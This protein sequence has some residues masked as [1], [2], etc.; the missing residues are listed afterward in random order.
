MHPLKKVGDT[1]ERISWEQAIDE[2]AEKLTA[3]VNEHG[4]RS[5]A[6]MMGGGN[7]GCP[8]P[9][10][11]AV[12]VIRGMGSQYHYSAL[13][14]E[15]TGRLWIGET[16]VDTWDHFKAL[17][18]K[19]GRINLAVPAEGHGMSAPAE[20]LLSEPVHFLGHPDGFDRCPGRIPDI[21]TVVEMGSIR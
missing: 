4:P 21:E 17:A 14:Q 2:I 16:D 8:T 15:L 7:L 13:A 9:V 11:F 1:F 5:L 20:V 3:I 19:D 10:P 12:N 6:L 18:T